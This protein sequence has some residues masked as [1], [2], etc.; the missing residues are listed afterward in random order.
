MPDLLPNA[1][2][3]V[4]P[5]YE[6]PLDDL[7]GDVL[8]PAMR[9]ATDMRVG[10]GFFSSQCL[11]QI[12]PGL[13]ELLTRKGALH[14][15]VS[16]ELSAED[17]EGVK[18][19]I[20]TPQA[21]I[22]AF[23][24]GLLQSPSSSLAAHAVDC[25]AYLVAKQR[26]LIRFVLMN[27]GMYHKKQW[28]F[29]D[30][31]H[32]AAVHGS[33]N[34][35]SRGLLANGEQMTVDRPWLDGNSSRVRVSKLVA[36]FD[37][38]WNNKHPE[39]LTLEPV[40]A[41]AFLQARGT[42]QEAP[43]VDEFWDAWRKDA[44][45]GKEPS[46]PPGVHAR[47]VPF[48]R[49]M[50]IPKGLDWHAPPYS[51]QAEAVAALEAAGGSGIL[52]IA[53]GGGKTLVSLIAVTRL[54]D[55][56]L[57]SL[58]LVVLVPSTP[59][60]DQWQTEV[61]K[62]GVEPHL[63]SGASPAQ[64]G[65]LL[66]EV[67]AAL[68]GGRSTAVLIASNQ[69]FA[70][71]ADLRPFVGRWAASCAT[72]LIGDEV[73]N[74]GAPAFINNP[75]NAFQF[76]IGLSATPIR[77]YDPDGTDQLFGYFRAAGTAAQPVFTYTLEQAINDRCLVP[78]RYWVHPVPFT[79][80]EMNRYQELTD[81][82]R[83]AGFAKDDDGRLMTNA[84]IGYLLRERR[85]LIEQADHK[86]MALR[87][88]LLKTD[89]HTIQRTLI[90]TSAKPVSAP[91]TGRQID[92]VTTLLND[93]GVIS[94]QFT[95]AETASRQAQE[96]L[97]KFGRGDYQVLTAMKVLD[98]GI[99]IPQTNVAFLLA[100]STVQREWVQRRGR[101]LRRAEGKL[102][103]DLHDFVVVPPD[104]QSPY[105]QRLLRSEL[106]RV[107]AFGRIALNEYDPGGAVEVVGHLERGDW[108]FQ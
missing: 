39:S 93:L 7:V 102:V 16:T 4:M 41:I 90:Y 87:A 23:A 13:A 8:I 45:A 91:H 5:V 71:D 14:L 34:A 36:Q 89:P 60:A 57:R 24:V 30:G 49:R 35:T 29:S 70:Q 78:Y 33:G 42:R 88:L 55:R 46:M 75:P 11:A 9:C 68:Q 76:R 52:S 37:R 106:N 20:T 101:I 31:E 26:L 44:D 82:L 17:L 92:Q 1:L 77:Q 66:A 98:E 43:T 97:E 107:I 22:D 99:D 27:R 47:H 94:H 51:H 38:Q 54:Q 59:L 84:R 86:V 65:E 25:L 74:L 104:S 67:S 19:G 40:Q 18:R 63:L 85:A 72:V 64:R 73:H 53:T 32:W 15:L 21:A 103:A 50:S 108:K 69:L 28:L 12:A 2:A 105:G 56:E 95:S 58:L 81:N 61:R 100:S 10:T 62:F 6:I 3:H 83:A 48:H 96:L 79:S 80:E